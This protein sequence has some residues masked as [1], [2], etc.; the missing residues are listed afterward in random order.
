MRLM[1]AC[2]QTSRREIH[3]CNMENSPSQVPDE[4]DTNQADFECMVR[5]KE[6]DESALTELVERH[7]QAVVGTAFRMLGDLHEAHDIAQKVFI[8]IWKSADRYE[9]TAKFTTWMFTITRNLV[10]NESRRRSRRPARSLEEPAGEME[11]ARHVEDPSQRPAD[12]E[13]LHGELRR[14]VDEAIRRLPEKQRLALVLRRFEMKTYEE[15]AA[16]LEVTVPAVK[17]LLFRARTY[18]RK[19]LEAHLKE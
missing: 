16:V 17:S 13:L 8:R 12:Q 1:V 4:G 9:P 2:R 14:A 6:G 7:Q 11:L 19:E 3:P 10:F 15:I 5:L 18:L